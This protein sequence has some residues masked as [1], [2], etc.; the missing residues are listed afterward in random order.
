MRPVILPAGLE[1][2]KLEIYIHKGDLRVLYNGKTTFFDLLPEEVREAFVLHMMGNKPAV[3][4]LK[5]D[6]GLTDAQQMLNQYIKC[7]F[8]NFDDIP[9][10]DDDGT[11]YPECWDCGRRGECAGEGKVCG[12]I[13]G[14]NGILTRRETEIF[15]LLIDGKSHKMI[16]DYFH[17]SEPT[18]QTQLKDMREKLGCHSSI[19]VM[20][21]A[22]KRRML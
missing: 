8:G 17:S 16:A 20:G 19:E 7:N 13:K 11:I 18:V 5:K 4:S 14:P 3:E 15:F 9:D 6:F 22:L 1:D 21:F 12:R 2:K 10:M